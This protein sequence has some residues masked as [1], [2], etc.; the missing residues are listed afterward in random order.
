MTTYII[1]GIN[2]IIAVNGTF[3]VFIFI[4]KTLNDVI[5]I[6]YLTMMVSYF[7]GIDINIWD[8]FLFWLFLLLSLSPKQYENTLYFGPLWERIVTE[9]RGRNGELVLLFLSSEMIS[10][11]DGRT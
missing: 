7:G 11:M 5:A 10:L 4:K 9:T 8:I 3:G 6:E 1:A 2:V